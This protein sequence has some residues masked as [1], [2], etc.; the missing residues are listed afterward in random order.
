MD[1]YEYILLFVVC[2]VG[3]LIANIWLVPWF[4]NKFLY[5]GTDG[6][7]HWKCW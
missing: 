6:K 7:W 4:Q 3:N 2:V 5:E 1:V